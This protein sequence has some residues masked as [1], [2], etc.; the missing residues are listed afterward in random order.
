MQSEQQYLADKE[1]DKEILFNQIVDYNKAISELNKKLN[2]LNEESKSEKIAHEKRMSEYAKKEKS[3]KRLVDDEI[4]VLEP[5]K[6]SLEVRELRVIKE[7]RRLEDKD[8]ALI[9]IANNLKEK[10]KEVEN[11]AD[12]VEVMKAHYTE[13][14]SENEGMKNDVEILLETIR[15]EKEETEK[16]LAAA[17]SAHTK[18]RI[19]NNTIL[20]EAELRKMETRNIQKEISS[21]KEVLNIRAKEL[22]EKEERVNSQLRQLAN[23]KNII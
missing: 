16:E 20:A 21:Q 12:E 22:A 23:A 17:K 18:E 7:D 11:E 14:V 3:A 8:K 2:S 1:R 6:K 15:E 5:Y 19:A 4:K 9:E 13:L 10:E